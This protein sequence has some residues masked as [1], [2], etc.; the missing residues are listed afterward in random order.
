MN[1]KVSYKEKYLEEIG[2]SKSPDRQILMLKISDKA[3]LFLISF[4]THSKDFKV[5]Q[6]QLGRMFANEI[7]LKYI[8]Q[9]LNELKEKKYIIE[10][11]SS[12]YI[13]L[14]KIQADYL[15]CKEL[16]EQRRKKLNKDSE[17]YRK[18]TNTANNT[19]HKPETSIN[20]N[21]DLIERIESL[22]SPKVKINGSINYNSKY[23][24][25]SLNKKMNGLYLNCNLV[26]KISYEQFET[27]FIFSYAYQA[28]NNDEF[29]YNPTKD[30]LL[31]F[32]VKEDTQ[33]LIPDLIDAIN[34][35]FINDDEKMKRIEK[36]IENYK[37]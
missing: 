21:T 31:Q 1:K 22:D 13:D 10:N 24:N 9:Y 34:I 18:N 17:K 14:E 37:L 33:I 23:F 27:L 29:K 26:D 11:D 6:K 12:Y 35:D 30:G 15:E 19:D 2:Y 7:N 8:K 5:S 20:T 36:L 3:K 16:V 28:M 4:F 32:L 25:S